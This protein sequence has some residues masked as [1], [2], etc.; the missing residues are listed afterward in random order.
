MTA[1]HRRYTDD[2]LANYKLEPTPD[3]SGWY[4][5]LIAGEHVG[6]VQR[7]YPS[8]WQA[9]SPTLAVLAHRGPGGFAKSKPAAV[10]DLVLG[11]DLRQRSRRRG[12]AS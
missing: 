3:T 12:G 5:V 11:L 4:R 7:R 10:A 6:F 8:G 9:V 2:E 1:V